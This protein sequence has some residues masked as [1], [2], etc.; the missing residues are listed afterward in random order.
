MFIGKFEDFRINCR[1]VNQNI[2]QKKRKRKKSLLFISWEDMDTAGIDLHIKT[3]VKHYISN[4]VLYLGKKSAPNSIS[5][6]TKDKQKLLYEYHG[7]TGKAITEK[8]IALSAEQPIQEFVVEILGDF[9]NIDIQSID[10]YGADFEGENLFPTP[11][12]F[13]QTEGAIDVTSFDTVSA[14]CDI[15]TSA[16]AILKE[17]LFEAAEVTLSDSKQGKL[18]F[19]Y[20]EAVPS[21]GYRLSV[22]ADAVTICGSDLRGFVQG[23]ETLIKLIADKKV[24]CCQISDAPFCDFRGVHLLLP[25]EDQMDFTKRLIKY[26]LSPMGYNH[27]I[28]EVS[29]ALEL[30]SHPEI[31]EAFLTA[32]KNAQAGLWP[33][34]P[35]AANGGGKLVRK[36]VMQDLVAYARSYGIEMIPEIACLGHVQHITLAHPDIAEV[37][38]RD[39]TQIVDTRFADT[40]PN[41][42]YAHSLCP[43]NPKSYE[44]IFD[45]TDD[46]ID[47]FQPKEFIHMGH[48]EVYQMGLCPKCRQ[49]T[50]AQILA[51]DLNKL[52][53]Y[54]T[55]KGLRIMIWGDMLQRYS[56]NL[57][58]KYRTWEALPHIPK[59]IV[60]LDFVWYEYPHIDIE[61]FPLSHGF[62]VIIGNLY[63]SHFP[64]YETR[65][66]KKGVFGGQLSTWVE[67][68]EEALSREG[69]FYDLL[70]TGQMLWSEQYSKHLRYSYDKVIGGIIPKL[71]EQISEKRYPSL[72]DGAQKTEIGLGEV[73]GTFDS[74]LFE[75]TATQYIRRIPWIELEVIANYTVSYSDGTTETIPVTYGG[76]IGWRYRRHNEP[77]TEM[78]YRHNGYTSTWETDGKEPEDGTL[79]CLEWIN[80]KPDTP[81]THISLTPAETALTEV[82][83]SGIFGIK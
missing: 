55:P 9:T 41:N 8:E 7:E 63:S 35:P 17:K 38:P 21:N 47:I 57:I 77:F 26:V 28:V 80:P 52:H 6:Y 44:I 54:I 64:R 71:R 25:A 18:H 66:R 78:Y 72:R 79:Y 13:L 24:P 58:K 3:D 15:A 22:A 16:V 4:V 60:L 49:K 19:H 36:E 29:G 67:T 74:I 69:K 53:D 68:S 31:N 42:F 61:E 48:D 51:E 10:I 65:I 37:A 23:V 76:N 43:S 34:I 82:I 75:H 56:F 2:P 32:I 39:F 70:L 20:E 33:Q 50:P 40:P 46:I 30:K 11:Q 83:V 59:D 12:Q 1:K 62:D 5:L 14:D 27:I 73:N 81:I 45:I